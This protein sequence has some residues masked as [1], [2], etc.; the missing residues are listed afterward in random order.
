MADGHLDFEVPLPDDLEERCISRFD[1][2]VAEE[3]IFYSP[4][5]PEIAEDQG[6]EVCKRRP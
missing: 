6:H 3:A 2:L 4:S 1:E 5:I